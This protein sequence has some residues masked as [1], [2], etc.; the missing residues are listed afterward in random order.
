MKAQRHQLARAHG[1]PF[2]FFASLVTEFWVD[3]SPVGLYGFLSD[4]DFYQALLYIIPTQR[5]VT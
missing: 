5:H 2:L 1:T 3:T 4:T